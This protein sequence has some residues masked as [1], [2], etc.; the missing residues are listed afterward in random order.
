MSTDGPI[1]IAGGGIAGLTA[2]LCLAA[3]G[4]RST[5]FERSPIF[6]EVGAGL[7]ISPNAARILEE[8]GL[9]PALIA[10]AARPNAVHVRSGRSGR[11]IVSLP[12]ADWM[13]ERY[14]APYFVI[15][16][17]DLQSSLLDAVGRSDMIDLR[18]GSAV[19]D[20]RQFSDRVE[21]AVERDRE[22]DTVTGAALIGAD[23]V[24]STIRRRVLGLPDAVYSGRTAWRAT[25]ADRDAGSLD[26]SATGLWIG[27]NAHMVHYPVSSGD[28]FNVV[29]VIKDEW[30]EETWSAAGNRRQ[31]TERL[32]DWHPDIRAIA[33]SADKWLKWALCGIDPNALWHKG[34]VC[35][36]GDAA[37]AMLPFLAQGAAMAIE[38]AAV[39]ADCLAD[40]GDGPE[41]A[42]E[43]FQ[44]SRAARVA[45]VVAQARRNGRI[46]HM[47]GP[48]AVARD[49]TMRT[50]GGH[51]I[52]AQYDWLYGWR[53]KASRA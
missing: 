34:R 23:G 37:H 13:T 31:L 1:L 44:R 25:I 22:M 33:E 2:A 14:G 46:Y 38:D 27:R 45:R 35:L 26:V 11:P 20:V 36:I 47:H 12:L 49:L 29:I 28:Q 7:Q 32:A 15:H 10:R 43:A 17:A 52:A 48:P 42:F 24:W 18:P 3:H 21:V 41:Y 4:I 8:L 51:R 53:R 16:R 6:E 40:H 9:G 5:I 30:G 39:I 50:L 19:V